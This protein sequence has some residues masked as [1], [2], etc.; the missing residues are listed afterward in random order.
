MHWKSM[1]DPANVQNMNAGNGGDLVKHTVYLATLGFLLKR[2]PWSQGMRLR[3]CHAGRGIYRVAV[4]NRGLLSC[5]HSIRAI[6]EA[7]PLESAQ[8]SILQDLGCWPDVAGNVEQHVEWYAGSALT[9][10]RKLADHPGSHTLD[11][12]ELKPK[13]RQILRGALM[14]LQ[15][16]ARL[17]WNVLSGE[18]ETK[19]FDGEGYIGQEIGK[20]GVQ[21][22]IL[23][24]PFALWVNPG[25][26]KRRDGY[27]R[28]FDA[29]VQRGSDA[30]S[31]MLFWAW[32]SQNEHEA[33]KDL[34]NVPRDGISCGYHGLRS[35]LHGAGLPFVRVRWFWEQWF[36]MW[37]VV[38]GLSGEHL[39]ELERE[40]QG[41]CRVVTALWN[42]CGHKC[43]ELEVKIDTP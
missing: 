13:T 31:L 37:I 28:I 20:W 29:L 12:Y 15:L 8:R 10:A 41:D 30:A 35:K 39:S 5:L 23:L 36:S 9:N 27:G 3:E 11:L 38:P 25:D 19:D 6:V 43:P 18:D 21:D 26:Q 33:K 40:I 17:S 42:R 32:G 1:D 14:D 16:P 7:V 22:L 24:D 34:D 2:K 4:N